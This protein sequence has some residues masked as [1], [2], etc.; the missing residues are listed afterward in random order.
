VDGSEFDIL[1][2]FTTEL[3]GTVSVDG[4]MRSI[5]CHSVVDH[6]RIRRTVGQCYRQLGDSLG[7][8]CVLSPSNDA[9]SFYRR[10]ERQRMSGYRRWKVS[11]TNLAPECRVWKRNAEKRETKP[12]NLDRKWTD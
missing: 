6:L 5:E 2:G 3:H 9:V 12:T 11:W 4:G 1:Y 10:K 8:V 7:C